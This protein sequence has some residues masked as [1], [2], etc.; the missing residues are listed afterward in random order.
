MKIPINLASQP[1]HRVRAMLLASIAVSLALAGTLAALIFLIL[2]DR[3]QMADVRHDIN[4]L[5]GELRQAQ[6]EQVRITSVVKKPENSEL[7]E[8]SVFINALI[9]RK[10]ISWTR[11]FSDLEKTL[12][13]NV[14]VAQIRP[15]L[16]SHN[17]VALDM[18]LAADNS[19]AMVQALVALENSPLFGEL[20]SHS[21][22]T[23][24]QSEPLYRYRIT[25]NYAQK[26]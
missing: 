10:G 6:A 13:Y 14:K 4:R 1:F 9:Y 21:M 2:A 7:L 20:L 25:V 11:I 19:D 17:G 23:P 16:N 3:A 24:T 12:P 5:N 26:L 8:R 22:Q 18:S 15:T